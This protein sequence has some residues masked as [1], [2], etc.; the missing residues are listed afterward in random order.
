MPF[1]L[2]GVQHIFRK[3][4]KTKET[5]NNQRLEN[6]VRCVLLLYNWDSR[7]FLA[8]HLLHSHNRNLEMAIKHYRQIM[9]KIQYEDGRGT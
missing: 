5:S 4:N 9:T 1:L 2:H 3:Y 8:E 7:V 6:G